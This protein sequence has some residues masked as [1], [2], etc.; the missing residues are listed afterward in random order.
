LDML[1]ARGV[2]GE[3]RLRRLLLYLLRHTVAACCCRRLLSHK[4]FFPAAVSPKRGCALVLCRSQLWSGVFYS[5][6]VGA[7]TA[8]A[9]VAVAYITRHDREETLSGSA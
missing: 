8:S 4:L 9:V 7:A 3:L 1:R 2:S 6:C 5:C